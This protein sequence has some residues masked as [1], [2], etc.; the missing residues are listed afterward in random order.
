MAYVLRAL[1]KVG[2]YIATNCKTIEW[3]G[4]STS[5]EAKIVLDPAFIFGVYP[6]PPWKMD[7]LVGYVAHEAFHCKELSDYILFS[8]LENKKKELLPGHKLYL[9]YLIETGEDIYINRVSEGSVWKHYIAKS[10]RHFRPR[11][12]RDPDLPPTPESLIQVW[13]ETALGGELL[14]SLHFDYAEPLEILFSYTDKILSSHQKYESPLERCRCRTSLYLEI[15]EQIA[16]HICAWEEVSGEGNVD[17]PDPGGMKKKEIFGEQEGGEGEPPKGPEKDR[18][19][20]SF[21]LNLQIRELLNER[22]GEDLTKDIEVVA[23]E[24]REGVLQ[25]VLVEAGTPSRVIPNPVL[26]ERLKRI[27]RTQRSAAR[28]T[29]L[30]TNRGLLSGKLDTRR[31]YRVPVNGKIFKQRERKCENKFWN[32]V[33]LVDASESMKGGSG[34][35]GRSWWIVQKTFISLYEAA[36]GSGNRLEVL[37]YNEQGGRCVISRLLHH[38]KMHTVA[39]V[40]RTPTGQGIIAAALKAPR[41]RQTLIIHLTDGEPNCGVP[42]DRAI[43]FCEREGIDLVTIGCFY[44]RDIKEQFEQQYKDKLYLM[45]SIERLP[46]GLER[47]IKRKIL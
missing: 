8:I 41:D 31:L 37:C 46:E 4:M 7:V 39:P 24:F 2:N 3:K 29:G 6:V 28:S 16:R 20:I 11:R 22:E 15:W 43:E 12:E 26:V 27:F 32:I 1:K 25:T 23:G 5:T 21:D 40:G 34:T 19:A 47:L 9:Q 38:K 10:W 42:T 18:T 14:T 30:K 45:D 35:G 17:F 13:G 36:K 33:I 44:N